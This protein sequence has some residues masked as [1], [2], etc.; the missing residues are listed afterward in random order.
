MDSDEERAFLIVCAAGF[1]TV[2][3]SLVVFNERLVCMANKL[4]L[5]AVISLA[6]GVM[7]FGSFMGIYVKSYSGFLDSGYS[8]FSA[9]FYTTMCF[10]GGI[11]FF[12]ILELIVLFF[13]PKDH[14]NPC[15]CPQV[16]II[17][18]TD[19]NDTVDMIIRLA[20]KK[21]F[22]KKK[23]LTD[24]VDPNELLEVRT[25]MMLAIAIAIHNLP[26]G[27]A[28]FVGSLA[29]PALGISLAIS[30][31]LHNVPEGMC[32]AIPI[33]YATNDRW[34]AFRWG[35]F[36]G[37][38]EPFGALLGWFVLK[39]NLNDSAHGIIF[40]F[41]SGMMIIIS[42]KELIPTAHHYDPKDILA[43]KF[44]VIGMMVVASSLVLF[45]F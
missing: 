16:A 31:G 40:G 41:V 25:G 38:V 23:S 9:C 29:D 20:E 18:S 4:F 22:E 3:G 15:N 35:V 26:E 30:I 2:L 42:L 17:D 19:D 39:N 8:E 36:C 10:F 7:I 11:V 27:L 13:A 45:V 1:S 6:A 37:L 43:T 32:V 14:S 12:F 33:Y 24:L 34:K 28:T 44:V 5:A 21:K